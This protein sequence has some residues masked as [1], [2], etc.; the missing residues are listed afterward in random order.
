MSSWW[1]AQWSA[2]TRAAGEEPPLSPGCPTGEHPK[3]GAATAPDRRSALP[4]RAVPPGYRATAPVGALQD[5]L[6]IHPRATGEPHLAEPDRASGLTSPAGLADP[7]LRLSRRRGPVALVHRTCTGGISHAVPKAERGSTASSVDHDKGRWGRT[8]G[9]A[10]VGTPFGGCA[11][12]AL[13][14]AVPPRRPVQPHVR[15]GL[16]RSSTTDAA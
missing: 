16:R 10:P 4:H 5:P 15:V 14:P 7:L 3:S 8:L 12:G 13:L 11:D 1:S 6:V 2:A 9:P